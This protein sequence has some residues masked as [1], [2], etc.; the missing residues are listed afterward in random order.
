MGDYASRV[1]H[2]SLDLFRLVR[3][4]NLQFLQQL[5]PDQWESVGIHAERGRITVRELSTH[6]A[7]HD[8]NHIE[9]IRKI[10]R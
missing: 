6:M 8:T 1:P 7:G 3:T 5:A 10:L 9:Q 2:E 4:A